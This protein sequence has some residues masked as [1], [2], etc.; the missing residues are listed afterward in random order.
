MLLSIGITGCLYSSDSGDPEPREDIVEASPDQ[1]D[2]SQ[3]LTGLQLF[4]VYVTQMR[5]CNDDGLCSPWSAQQKL[6][7]CELLDRYLKTLKICD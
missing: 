7:L 1:H 4:G 6:N 2:Y 5:S 3:K